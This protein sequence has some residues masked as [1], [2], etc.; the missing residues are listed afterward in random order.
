MIITNID[1]LIRS[2]TQHKSGISKI[3]FFVPRKIETKSVCVYVSLDDFYF[4]T[5]N[6]WQKVTLYLLCLQNVHFWTHVNDF[7]SFPNNRLWDSQTLLWFLCYLRLL[8]CDWNL[9][10]ILLSPLSLVCCDEIFTLGGSRAWQ[11]QDR[12]PQTLYCHRA[13]SYPATSAAIMCGLD[14]YHRGFKRKHENNESCFL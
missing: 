9:I 8:R 6:G 2:Q 14:R 12:S 10:T 13:T 4:D 11:G 3:V 7:G 1:M 5:M